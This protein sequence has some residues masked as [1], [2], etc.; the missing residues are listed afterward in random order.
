MSPGGTMSFEDS[1]STAGAEGSSKAA[2]DMDRYGS[3]RR[4]S[5]LVKEQMR[6]AGEAA[7]RSWR[8]THKSQ[9]RK[10]RAKW[11]LERI[12]SSVFGSA[13]TTIGCASFLIGCQIFIFMKIGSIV[14]AVTMIAAVFALVPLPAVLMLV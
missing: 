4:R 10:A 9:E 2:D 1:T 6:R 12:G 14:V 5:S 3:L 8:S 11:A 13:L 7:W